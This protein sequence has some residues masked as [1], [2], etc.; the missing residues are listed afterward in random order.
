MTPDAPVAVQD[1]YTSPGALALLALGA[2]LTHGVEHAL[3]AVWRRRLSRLTPLLPV[4]LCC[5]GALV[6]GLLPGATVGERLM[7]AL[8]VGLGAHAVRRTAAG[9]RAPK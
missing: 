4:G 3:S 9:E 6:S 7:S 2:A 5:L 8:T 1:L